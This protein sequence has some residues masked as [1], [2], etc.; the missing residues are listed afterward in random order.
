MLAQSH[1]SSLFNFAHSLNVFWHQQVFLLDAFS[2]KIYFI[3]A[4]LNKAVFLNSRN[5]CS[6][7]S[8]RLRRGAQDSIFSLF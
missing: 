2:L 4:L 6:D 5:V 3:V 8:V 7:I 1:Q